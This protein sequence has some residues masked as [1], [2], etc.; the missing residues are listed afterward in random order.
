ML[1]YIQGDLFTAKNKVLLHACNCRKTWGSGVAYTFSNRYPE[2]YEKHREFDARPGDIQVIDGTPT[3]V[4][5]FTSD[6]YG[7]E[8]DTPLDILNH[9][10]KSLFKLALYYKDHES[11]EIASPK[12]NAG[13]FH[14]PWKSTEILIE[15]FLKYNPNFSWDVYVL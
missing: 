9:T 12:I 3:I 5:L 11:V 2:A 15:N 1:K 8:T 14:V 13:L 10:K 7:K 4:C 6:G